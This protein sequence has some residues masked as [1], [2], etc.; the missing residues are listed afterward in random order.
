MSLLSSLLEMA[1][2]LMGISSVIPGA[3]RFHPPALP[4]KLRSVSPGLW[5]TEDEGLFGGFA[6][7]AGFLLERPEGN[8]FIYSSAHISRYFQH[9]TE[10]G[11]VRNIFLNH[12][13]EASP[14]VMELA[15]Q[16]SADIW[17]HK[18]E[19][20]ICEEKGTIPTQL[21][22][23]SITK[24]NDDLTAFHTPGHTEGVVSYLWKNP[25]E[26]GCA[27]LFTGD[28][29]ISTEQESIE[30]ILSFHSYQGNKEDLINSLK[31]LRDLESNILVPGLANG[32]KPLVAM[33]WTADDRSRV[34]NRLIESLK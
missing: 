25:Q 17:V 8:T 30:F 31:L 1:K 26:G 19:K 10:L 13:D 5:A 18:N 7:A 16:F 22:V 14:H 34:L 33:T 23:E 11:G 29:L 15:K 3:L 6:T 20:N 24:F 21:F 4:G 2:S 9:I 32:G 12:Q 28:T 27:Y